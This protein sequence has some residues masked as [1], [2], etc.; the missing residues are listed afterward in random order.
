MA[1]HDRMP[2]CAKPGDAEMERRE[3]KVLIIGGGAAGI[4]IGKCFSQHGLDY[5]IVERE[6][7][8]GGNW[9]FGGGSSRVYRSTHLISSKTNSQ[10]SDF[11]MPADFPE[12]PS[13]VQFLEYLRLTARTFDVYAHACLGV[14]VTR[15]VPEA[16]GW[17]AELS[18]GERRWYPDVVVANGVL[19]EPFLPDLPGHFTGEM[20][21]SSLYKD[22][23]IF[24]GKRVLIVGGGNSG[25]DIAVDAAARAVRTLHSTRRGYHYMP[26]FINGRAT[27]DWLME[28]VSR[29]ETPDAYWKHVKETFKLAGFD[30]T[31]YGLPPPDH[32]IHQAHPIMNS[33][34]LY[35]VG[36]GD[37]HP[38]PDIERLDG[39]GVIFVGG[40]RE[41]V[42]LIVLATGF[43][44]SMPFLSP[45]IIDWPAGVHHFF[46][47]ALPQSH[48]NIAFA[49]YFN[50]PSGFGNIAN[51]LSRFLANYFVSKR[52]GSQ[53]WQ[54]LRQLKRHGGDID[55]GRGQ[56]I[57]TR[58]H[59]HELDLWKYI[60]TVNFLTEKLEAAR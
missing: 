25:C 59:D 14:A 10:F 24:E 46:L 43:K 16:E 12:Y 15:L 5:D 39:D 28:I 34:I 11:P 2:V 33:T 19:R 51:T 41:P 47:N 45:D 42:D 9:Y 13:H 23:D 35:H 36:H 18:N 55:V 17:R 48:D 60:K 57:A 6:D 44:V 49:G 31:D 8:L 1:P 3:D 54:V 21:H 52:A 7:D 40:D 30:G 32:D 26:K 53:A 37:V 29:F 22:P 4:A 50:I 27:Q 20:I 56:F 58:R 38:R